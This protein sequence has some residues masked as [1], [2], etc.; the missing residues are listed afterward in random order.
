MGE[1]REVVLHPGES[2]TVGRYALKFV[3][4]ERK[5]EPHREAMVANV[6]VTRGSEDLGVMTPRMNQYASMREPVG[7]P[8]VRTSAREDLYLSI[9]NADPEKQTLGLLVRVNPMVVW[10][11]IATGLMAL[12]GVM[13][14]IPRRRPVVATV[15]ASVPVAPPGAAAAR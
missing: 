15:S 13:A 12:G 3:S 7:T 9:M 14:L 10:L 1:S 11:W 6:A 8:T 5:V 4:L 2:V